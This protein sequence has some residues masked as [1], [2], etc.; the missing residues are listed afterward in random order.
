MTIGPAF[1]IVRDGKTLP[2]VEGISKKYDR[3]V[4]QF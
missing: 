4:M 2:S 3:V 1:E